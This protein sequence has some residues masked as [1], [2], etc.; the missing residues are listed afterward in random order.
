MIPTTQTAGRTVR[1]VVVTV[2]RMR[3]NAQFDGRPLLPPTNA[4]ELLTPVLCTMA[5]GWVRTQNSGHIFSRLWTKV[6]QITFACAGVS[7]VCKPFSDW[8]YLVAFRRYS[9]SSREV[10]RNRAEIACFWAAKFRAEGAPNSWRNFM[11]MGRHRTCGKVWWRSAKGPRPRRLCS[12]KKE[13]NDSSK[14]MAGGQHSWRA[15]IIIIANILMVSRWCHGKKASCSHGTWLLSAPQLSR[16]LKPQPGMPA[17]RR[18][19]RLFE[20]RTSTR[21][22]NGLTSFSLLLLKR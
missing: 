1:H 6:H 21:L 3:G 10:V 13:I 17:R 16:T 14:T 20:S 8:W 5:V 22:C 15:A 19:E 4:T 18:N 11:N 7:V 9:R 12:E 2:T